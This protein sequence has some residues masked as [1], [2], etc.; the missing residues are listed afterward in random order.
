MVLTVLETFYVL[1]SDYNLVFITAKTWG[2][3]GGVNLKRR[4]DFIFTIIVVY[5]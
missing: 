4:K 5:Y 3:G 2:G 1:S